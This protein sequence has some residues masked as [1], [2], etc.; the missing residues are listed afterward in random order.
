MVSRETSKKRTEIL[1]GIKDSWAV[2]LGLVPLG[3]AFGLVVGQSGF[4]WWW[5][6]IFSIIIY[7]GSM[8]F[9]ALNLILT[10]VGPIS[11]AITGF[12]VN[13]RHIFYG[14]TYPRHAVRSRIGRAYSTYALTD[15]SYAIVSARPNVQRI[16]GSR[17]LAIQVF[18]H[19]MWVSSGVLGAVAGSAIP[20]GLKGMEFALTALFIVLAWESF[21]NN[22]DW[23][24]VFFAVAFSLIGL[25]LVP[26]QM[27][28]FAL[29]V[30]FL[31]LLVRNASSRIDARLTW[32]I[33]D[34]R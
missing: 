2:A 20:Q 7:A 15:E 30:Y 13:F 21:R 33:G 22:Q 34:R 11:A 16:D 8:E 9:L 17:V 27:L 10:G 28:I 6:P 3:L 31:L 14:L 12:M 18:C 26:H 23:S 25:G 24:L 1:G 32:K 5:A 29:V 19:V 4:A